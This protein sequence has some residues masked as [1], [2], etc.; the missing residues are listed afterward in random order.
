MEDQS[1]ML[2]LPDLLKAL[3]SILICIIRSKP[4]IEIVGD[5]KI[6][7]GNMPF[8]VFVFNF[9]YQLLCVFMFA[10]AVVLNAKE[11]ITDVINSIGDD[12]D[13]A[14]E[15]LEDKKEAADKFTRLTSFDKK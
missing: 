5:N 7:I 8:N 15:I 3:E 13:N 1:L 10:K 12:D 4:I 11:K 2:S 6:M 14:Q 9:S